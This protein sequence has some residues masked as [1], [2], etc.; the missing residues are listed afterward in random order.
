M[1]MLLSAT[2]TYT[3]GQ[4][5]VQVRRKSNKGVVDESNYGTPLRAF[6]WLADFGWDILKTSVYM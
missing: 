3:P 1:S 4:N 5:G 6:N 2:E